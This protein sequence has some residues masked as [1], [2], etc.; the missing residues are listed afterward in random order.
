[1]K[2]T[3][4]P[5]LHSPAWTTQKSLLIITWDEDTSDPDNH[6]ATVV[7]GSRG[8]VPAG[9]TSATRYD[10][11]STG[12]TIEAALGLPPITANDEY[13]A[14]LNDA[15]GGGSVSAGSTLTTGTPNVPTGSAITFQ[16]TT[17]AG[18]A[19]S[20]NWIGI[21]PTGVVPG[22]QASLTWQYAP[23]TGG[24]ACFSTGS[25]PGAGAYAAWYCYNDGYTA[26][27][28]PVDFTVT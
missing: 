24:S 1:M 16:Y 18:T 20:T 8:T 26:L 10:H 9:A 14:T 5:I 12:R 4:D 25:L 28:G 22:Q 21:Y 15:F 13:A 27:M 2:Q 3:L 11:Y 7:L 6:V 23:G 17:P 19:S